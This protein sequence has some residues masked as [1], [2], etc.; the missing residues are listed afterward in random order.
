[1]KLVYAK[2][3]CSLSVHIL[4][5]ELKKPYEAIRV[6]L[7]NKEVLESYNPRGYVPALELDNGSV[8]AEGIS[9][10]QFLA[11]ENESAFF[12][13]SFWDRSRCVEW[14]SFVSSEL[15]KGL[16]PLFHREGLRPEFL[17]VTLDR[18]HNRLGFLEEQLEM[19][20][21]L[22]GEEYTIADMY[23]LAILRIA[24]HVGVTFEAFPAISR[25]KR[26]L[27]SRDV[28]KKV[29]AEEEAADIETEKRVYDPRSK[30]GGIQT[31]A[32]I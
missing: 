1:M 5:E 26:E 18:V 17:K 2:G 7:E 11:L 32:R 10:L 19:G 9:I 4:L 20:T 21:Y 31:D 8:M 13:I 22:M 14:L 29:I 23:T 24:E 12:P 15:H 16:G 25:Y 28:I 3:A 30:W 6:S 27:E